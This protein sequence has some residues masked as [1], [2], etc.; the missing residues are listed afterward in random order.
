MTK[1][2]QINIINS[3]INKARENLRLLSFNL[4]FWGVMIN[5]MSAF[6]YFF[7]PIVE[8]SKYSVVL[9]WTIIPILGMIYMIRWNIKRGIEIGYETVLDRTIKIIWAVFGLGW[10]IILISSLLIGKSP[11]PQILFLL[12]LVL[13]MN[14]LITK[15]KPLTF[16]GIFL[17]IFVLIND[18][19]PNI[20]YLIVNMIGVTLGMLIPALFLYRMKN[21]G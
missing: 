14:G 19:N 17:L 4:I 15:F 11:V 1:E 7:G 3:T 21:S 6:H 20:N 2:D 10:I 16:G 18:T 5:L 8:F 9:Y 12:G 13:V